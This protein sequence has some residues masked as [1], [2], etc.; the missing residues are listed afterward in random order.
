MA[1]KNKLAYFLE[2]AFARAFVG[3]MRALPEAVGRPA[4]RALARAVGKIVSSRSRM[5]ASNLRLAFPDADEGRIRQWVRECWNNLGEFIW[6]FSQ[7]PGMT[8]EDYFKTVDVEGMEHLRR[9]QAAGKG[10]I[11]MTAHYT[12]WERLTQLFSF[13]GLNLA[14]I[15]RRMKNPYV[16]DFITDIRSR[17]GTRIFLHK[18]AVR[19]SIRWL[20]QGF[21]VGMLIDQRITD[22]GAQVP[23]FNRP[24]YT[25]T[26]P[27]ILALRLGAPIHPVHSR[28]VGNRLKILIDPAV[29]VSGLSAN[30]EGI[31]ALTAKLNLVVESWVRAYPPAWL[32]IHD[33][34]K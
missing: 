28:R 25:T 10:I 5:A 17:H 11:L 20:K 33:R 1:A 34:W 9:S 27:A 31:L 3:G 24:A 26:L 4:G 22:G 8:S 15:A 7:I 23:F 13:S 18:N 29:D 32:W 6:E 16:N 12:N 21:T 19:E 2:Y 14:V 30:E